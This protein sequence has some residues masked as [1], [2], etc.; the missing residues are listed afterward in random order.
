VA[1]PAIAAQAPRGGAGAATS[2][3]QAIGIVHVHSAYSHDGRDPLDRLRDRA[4][5]LGIRFV[6]LTDHAEDFDHDRFERF[7]AECAARSDATVSLI[8]GLEFRFAGYRGLHLLACGL[9]RWV[10]PETPE[11]FIADVTPVAALTVMAHPVL[12]SYRPPA[13]VRAGIGAI[14]VWNAAYN[15][16][17]LPDPRAMALL[18]DIRATRPAVV[19]VAGLDQHDAANDRRTRIVLQ[20]EDDLADPLAAMR[21]A[22]F[23]NRGLTMSFGAR[24]DWPAAGLATLAAARAVLDGIEQTQE[25]VTR[26]WR[27]RARPTPPLGR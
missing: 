7:R 24:V 19:A 26:A 3:R 25:R 22:R 21:A 5:A 20:H 23:T 12:A 16:R 8:P 10:S 2:R 11:A 17:Y 27:R 4:R 6:A 18:R 1:A 13:A 9:E 14:E 15:T